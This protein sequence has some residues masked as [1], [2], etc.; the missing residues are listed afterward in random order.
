MLG[1]PKQGIYDFQLDG[2][3]SDPHF[4]L[5]SARGLRATEVGLWGQYR[6]ESR[7]AAEAMKLRGPRRADLAWIGEMEGFVAEMPTFDADGLAEQLRQIQGNVAVLTQSNAQ[8]LTVA[9]DL[10]V[11]GIQADLLSRSADRSIDSWVARSLGDAPTSLTK[12][13]FQEI[14]SPNAPIDWDEAW[15]LLRSITKANTKY[16]NLIEVAQRLSRGIIPVALTRRRGRLTVSTVHRAKGLEFDHVLLLNTEDWYGD[17]DSAFGRALYVAITRPRRRLFSFR[18]R[19]TDSF[20][21]TCDR[22]ER[23]YKTN[24]RGKGTTGFEV[25]GTDWRGVTPPGNDDDPAGAQTLLKELAAADR[26]VPVEVRLNAYGSTLSRPR[27]DAYVHDV[28]IGT[29][30]E[31]FTEAFLSRLGK[32]QDKWPDI[33]GTFFTGVETV[34]GPPQG[35]PVG[36]NGLWLS[37]LILGPATLDW[38]RS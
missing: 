8:A 21:K 6:A 34:P 7:D 15:T 36:R 16:L 18:R 10:Y 13:Q 1:D 27:Y 24:Y 17:R 38:R 5:Q 22:T 33:A 29:L 32:V 20:W 11:Q 19:P 31:A 9:R 28:C 35:G 2:D 25:R 30:G 37:P 23:A 3:F 26:P 4:L 14:A 12:E